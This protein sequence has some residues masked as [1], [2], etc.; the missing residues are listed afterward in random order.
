MISIEEGKDEWTDRNTGVSGKKRKKGQF[1]DE[2]D[3]ET[4]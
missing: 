3:G 2:T 4:E 1:L